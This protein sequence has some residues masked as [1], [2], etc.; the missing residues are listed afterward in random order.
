MSILFWWCLSNT[1]TKYINSN[2]ASILKITE[3]ASMLDWFG[4]LANAKCFYQLVMS[5]KKAHSAGLSWNPS[6]LWNSV[7][8]MS[9][10]VVPMQL[11]FCISSESMSVS[12]ASIAT[13]HTAAPVSNLV[14]GFGPSEENRTT[15]RVRMRGMIT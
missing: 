1:T 14:R 8:R 7:I 13:Q 4:S 12:M 5:R 11:N 15:H 3:L 10:S 2:T 9:L 6:S